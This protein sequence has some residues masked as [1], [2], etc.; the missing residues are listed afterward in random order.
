MW[1]ATTARSRFGVD[2]ELAAETLF[3]GRE[4]ELALLERD[5]RARTARAVDAAGDG[6]R[7]ARRRQE[8]SRLGV[9]RGDRRPA[10]SRPLAAGALPAVRRRHHVLGARRDREGRGRGSSRRTRPAEALAKLGHVADLFEDESDRCVDHGTARAA[11]R[12]AGRGGAASAG[13]RRSRPGGATWRLSLRS[14]RPCLVLEDLHWADTALLDFVEHLLDWTADVPL[15]VVA[16]ARPELYDTRPGWG[17]GRR[18]S[19]TIGLLA[20]VRRRHCAARLLAARAV[21]DARGDP[22]GSP[23]A[24]RRQPALRGAVRAHARARP[25]PL[26]RTT[27]R[28]PCRRSSPLASTHWRPS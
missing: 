16:T 23:R 2:T 25:G 9:S 1:R 13:R 22:S 27:C 24:R 19:A 28:R 4:S 10:G 21:G 12:R 11:R 18:N 15:M 7:G 20:A 17:G 5:V 8:P 14:G 6:G 26:R 3:V